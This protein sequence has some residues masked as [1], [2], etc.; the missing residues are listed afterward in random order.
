MDG[1]RATTFLNLAQS[2]LESFQS[3]LQNK[4]S[5]V[6]VD[7]KQIEELQE[8]LQILIPRYIDDETRLINLL[9]ISD[10][11][12]LVL[13]IMEEDSSLD[14]GENYFNEYDDANPVG[15]EIKQEKEEPII[16]KQPKR[17]DDGNPV[18]CPI[19]F[20]E[21]PF[22]ECYEFDCSH[23]YCKD[24]IFLSSVENAKFNFSYSSIVPQNLLGG[25]DCNSR[26]GKY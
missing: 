2:T 23:M 8:Q 17:E 3:N 6:L 11:I 25:L 14:S 1:L 21:Y 24:V 5:D 19:C 12:S 16:Q 18:E 13:Q 7:K 10:Q 9:A 15:T 20:E 26:C 4:K 22:P